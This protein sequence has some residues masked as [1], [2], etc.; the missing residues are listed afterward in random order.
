MMLK[1]RCTVTLAGEIACSDDY[2]AVLSDEDGTTTLY[3]STDALTLG[4]AYAL[5]AD[6]FIKSLREC[7]EEEQAEILALLPEGFRHG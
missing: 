1:D 3:C 6:E 5:I 2:V 7:T 4:Y